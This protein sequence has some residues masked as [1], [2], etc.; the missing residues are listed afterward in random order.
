MNKIEVR[1]EKHLETVKILKQHYLEREIPIFPVWGKDE[2]GNCNCRKPKCTKQGK[3]PISD[4]GFHNATTD[5][6][7]ITHWLD[8]HL[9]CGWAIPTGSISGIIVIDVDNKNGGLANWERLVN[10]NNPDLSTSQFRKAQRGLRKRSSKRT[11][12]RTS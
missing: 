8:V 12:N 9:D 1:K 11:R 4:G 7:T 5:I 6:G 3:H 10:E 2:N